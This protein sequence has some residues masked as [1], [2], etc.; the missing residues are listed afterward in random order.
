MA[1][2]KDEHSTTQAII[3]TDYNLNK[4]ERVEHQDEVGLMPDSE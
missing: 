2:G 3:V 4:R 1:E